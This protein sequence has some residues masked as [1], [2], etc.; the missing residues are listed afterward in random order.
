MA[1]RNAQG[2]GSIRQRPDGTWE[3]R[4]TTGRDPG[5][6][7][8]V[9]KSVYGK[10]QKEVRQKLT[11]ATKEMD[12]GIYI[13]PTKLTVGA[14]I[15]IWL[16]EYAKNTVKISTHHLYSKIC[17]S[18]IKPN[19]SAVKLTALSAPIIQNLCNDLHSGNIGKSALSAKTIKNIHG[20]LH[21]ALQQAV[22]I[23]YIRVNPADA[24]NLPRIVKKD[25][26]PLDKSQIAK[27]MDAIEGHPFETL[28]LVTLLTGMRQSETLGLRWE[29]VD[30]E[31]GTLLVNAQLLKDSA[32]GGY[33]LDTTKSNKPRLITPAVFVMD[34]LK[35]Y[36]QQQAEWKSL[37]HDAW[38]DSGYVFTNELGEHLKH[39]TVYKNYKRIVADLGI[40]AAR[41]HDLRHSYAVVA[42]MSGDDVKTVQE[43][44][45]HHTAAFTLDVY[46]HVT[47]EMKRNSAARMDE[48]IK[49]IKSHKG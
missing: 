49:G 47:E 40:P 22:T 19:L 34:A 37:A 43:N 24:C 17:R 20:V 23:G 12:D 36:K 10:T 45:G 35:K 42:L 29:C 5:T 2:S 3:A 6:G 11:K 27:F 21:K 33:Y 25:I 31:K 28:Y 1:K 4:Y 38:V 14:W 7:R 46:G 15:D 44:L 39:M 16:E 30:F 13:E 26:K 48:F 32:N 18:Y 41:Y 9:Q 8:Q